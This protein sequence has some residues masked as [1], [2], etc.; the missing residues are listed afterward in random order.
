MSSRN[1]QQ[2]LVGN[3]AGR[4]KEAFRGAEWER[5]FREDKREVPAEASHEE[6][7]NRIKSF[8]NGG[9]GGAEEPHGLPS[10]QRAWAES[11]LNANQSM[12]NANTKSFPSHAVDGRA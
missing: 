11:V 6:V 9:G 1:G 5:G 10:R 3:S 12:R 4:G 7:S 8:Q 2:A